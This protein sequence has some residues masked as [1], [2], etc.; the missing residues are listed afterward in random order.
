MGTDNKLV[1]AEITEAIIGAAMH[2]LN[3]LKPGLD[4]KIYER[5]L[6][7]TLKKRG[8]TVDQQRVFPVHFEGETVG[9]LVSDLVVGEKVIADPKVVTNFNESHDAQMIGYMTITGLRVSILL[10]FKYAQ[11]KWKRLVQ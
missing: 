11:L 2:V 1:H 3:V 5:A 7:I 6:A 4:E 8:Y 9:T 10:N